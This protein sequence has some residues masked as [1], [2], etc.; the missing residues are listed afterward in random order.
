MSPSIHGVGV[1]D[2]KIAHEITGV[3]AQYRVALY[4][5]ITPAAS[6]IL[7]LLPESIAV[8]VSTLSCSM[9]GAMFHDM[10]LTHQHSSATERF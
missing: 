10:G 3:S 4:C 6:I 8:C 9:P 2:S 5:S 7:V 1:P